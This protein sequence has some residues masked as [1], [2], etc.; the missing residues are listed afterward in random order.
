MLTMA[1]AGITAGGLPAP[2]PP[3]LGGP[4]GHEKGALS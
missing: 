3:V 1:G 2:T 4:L